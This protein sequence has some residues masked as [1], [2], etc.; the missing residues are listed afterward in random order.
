MNKIAIEFFGPIFSDGVLNEQMLLRAKEVNRS[1]THKAF[2]KVSSGSVLLN[3]PEIVE[4]LNNKPDKIDIR[5]LFDNPKTW[6]RQEGVKNVGVLAWDTNRIPCRDVVMSQ[7][8]APERYNYGK[9]LSKMDE[10]W[11]T[12]KLGENAIRNSGLKIPVKVIP[13]SIINKFND[14]TPLKEIINVTHHQSGLEISESEKKFTVFA[15]GKWTQKKD[16][17]SLIKCICVGLPYNKTILVLK[18][19]DPQD[20]VIPLIQQVKNSLKLPNVPQII[21]V[22]ENDPA[23]L[24]SLYQSCDVYVDMS[25]ATASANEALIAMEEGKICILPNNGYYPEFINA[26]NCLMINCVPE[27]VL[28]KDDGNPE[29][30]NH[31]SDQ[32]WSKPNEIEFIMNIQNVFQ[33][34]EKDKKLNTF[35]AIKANAK[36]TV[37]KH[38]SIK[39]LL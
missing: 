16:F 8:F 11:V 2:I 9:Q 3:D 14:K 17:E 33:S 28:Y 22:S 31:S 34:W 36:E 20:K 29:H 4:I 5:V 38:G 25:K 6:E 7:G 1:N 39:Y 30:I 13:L 10:I 35:K 21:L 32:L 23:V 15:S 37:K 18:I 19:D 27:I 12:S 26:N 24:K